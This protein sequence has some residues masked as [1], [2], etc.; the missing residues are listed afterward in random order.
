MSLLVEEGVGYAVGL[1]KIIRTDETNEKSVLCFRPLYPEL[2]SH[3][4]IAW[5]KNQVL[6]KCAEIFLERL[7]ELI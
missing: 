3:L 7:K 4:D 5:K 6:S 1:D 2:K